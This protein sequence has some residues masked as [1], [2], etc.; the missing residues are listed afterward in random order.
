M[1]KHSLSLCT[2]G[3]HDHRLKMTNTLTSYRITMI[4]LSLVIAWGLKY[5]YSHSN[6][7]DL[8]W[9]LKP[10]ACLVQIVSDTVFERTPGIGYND[11]ENRIIIA[12]TCSGVNFMIILKISVLS[13]TPTNSLAPCPT[14]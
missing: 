10:T 2:T 11:H 8:N 12:P 7:D 5:H 6:S 14:A 1:I 13:M 3:Y 4:A 9:I